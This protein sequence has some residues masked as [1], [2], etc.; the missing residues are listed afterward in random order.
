[1]NTSAGTQSLLDPGGIMNVNRTRRNLVLAVPV[2]IA[3]AATRAIAAD[4]TPLRIGVLR[5]SFNTVIH[6]IA[7]RGGYYERNGLAVNSVDFR[8]G[9]GAPGIESLMRGDL[10]AYVGTPA[11]TTRVDSRAIDQQKASPLVVVASGNP[12]NTTLVLRKDIPFTSLEDLRGLRLGVSSPGSDH[13]VHFRYY[14]SEKHLTTASLDLKLLPVGGSNMPPALLSKQIDG[15]LHSEPTVSIAVVKANGKVA[16][17]RGQFGGA[18]EAP[19]LAVSVARPWVASHRD[20][21]QRMVDALEQASIDYPKMPKSDVIRMF[22]EYE[23]AEPEVL[24]LAYQNADPRL[25]NLHKMA[26]AHW[27]VAVAAMREHKE[28]TPALKPEDMF[29]FSFSKL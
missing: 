17:R 25:F 15:F 22:N 28:V 16:M 11:E 24:D 9:E 6:G 7:L 27:K 13:L 8:S 12:G 3:G 20:V 19:S 26:D 1:V 5:S 18:A 29:D 23:R 14:L 4:K 21:V 10:D 2:V